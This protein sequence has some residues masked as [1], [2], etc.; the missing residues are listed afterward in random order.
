MYNEELNSLKTQLLSM[1]TSDLS[2][3]LPLVEQRL[4]LVLLDICVNDYVEDCLFQIRDAVERVVTGATDHWTVRAYL[5]GA[6]EALR[7][8]LHLCDID[9][10][11]RQTAVGF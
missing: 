7:D 4:H 6:I 1:E 5:L 11:V 9:T 2:Q 10:N 3:L 8:E